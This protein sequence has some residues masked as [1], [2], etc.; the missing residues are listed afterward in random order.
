[1]FNALPVE[2]ADYEAAFSRCY[3]VSLS[4][5]ETLSG[6]VASLYPH[7]REAVAKDGVPLAVPVFVQINSNAPFL[8]SHCLRKHRPIE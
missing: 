8:R 6:L 1:M 2:S 3:M 4:Q 7:L 5:S